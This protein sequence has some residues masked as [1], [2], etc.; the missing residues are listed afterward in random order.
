MID[1]RP[2]LITVGM[3][4]CAFA[5]TM[6]LPALV[7]LADANQDWQVFAASSVATL[8]VG[9]LLV[10]VAPAPVSPEISLRTGFVLT[11][12]VW[13][14]AAAFAGLPFVGVGLSYTDAYFE[15][16]SGLTTT[17]STVLIHLD[18]LPRGIL[19][20]RSIL[21]M[22]GG[23]GIVVTAIIL[24]P[25]LGIGGM[26]LFLTESSDTSEKLLPRAIEVSIAITW[27]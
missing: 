5:M 17:G 21:Q 12:S 19:L 23:I 25:F 2:I 11:T 16:M 26:Q 8:F 6:L 24:L 20:W 22:I 15:A 3:T 18:D 1:S 13:L 10:L 14:A 27:I 4:L 9:G 7:D